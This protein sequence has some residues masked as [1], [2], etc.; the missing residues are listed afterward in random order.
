MKLACTTNMM[1]SLGKGYRSL[2]CKIEQS[3]DHMTERLMD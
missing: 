1:V 2:Y 3:D